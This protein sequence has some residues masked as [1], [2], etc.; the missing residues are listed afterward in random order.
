MC[1]PARGANHRPS[2][3]HTVSTEAGVGQDGKPWFITSD[4]QT[5]MDKGNT[6]RTGTFCKLHWVRNVNDVAEDRA[7][8]A[9][10][11]AALTALGIVL[12][13]LSV[14]LV[15]PLMA[16][17]TPWIGPPSARTVRPNL[18]PASDTDLTPAQHPVMKPR[19]R[20]PSPVRR[21]DPAEYS[22]AA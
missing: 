7:R 15:K 22:V 17:A 18:M 16:P 9:I 13:D 11:H 10:W 12:R 14:F 20:S 8:Y 3:W 5:T 21:I 6:Y 4:Q 2:L 1:E 19:P